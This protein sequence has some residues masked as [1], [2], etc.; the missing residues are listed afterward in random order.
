[1]ALTYSFD[2]VVAGLNAVMPY[3]WAKFLN[4]R[5]NAVAPKYPLD[6]LTRFAGRRQSA[7]ASRRS[8][9]RR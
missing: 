5:I 3:D 9:R 8:V 6:G 4:E 7:L 2:D 1:M